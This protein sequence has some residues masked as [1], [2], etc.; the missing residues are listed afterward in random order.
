MEIKVGMLTFPLS[1]DRH[2]LANIPNSWLH[3][4]TKV[5]N[6]L[7]SQSLISFDFPLGMGATLVRPYGPV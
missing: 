7:P 4:A 2:A 6:E 3:R 5:A 1:E